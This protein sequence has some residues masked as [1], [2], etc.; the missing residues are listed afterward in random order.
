MNQVSD[1]IV[2]LRDIAGDAAANAATRVKPS[3]SELSQIDR[4][5]DDNTWHD[6]PVISKESIK[7]QFKSQSRT[8]KPLSGQDVQEVAVDAAQAADTAGP[9]S[10][11]QQDG[12]TSGVDARAGAQAGVQ[13][14][15][16]RANENI[17]DDTK[18]R[19]KN[20]HGRVMD[21]LGS[22]IPQERRDRTIWRLKKMVVEVQGHKCV[23]IFQESSFM[24]TDQF[25]GITNK[26]SRLCSV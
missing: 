26:P 10:R 22:K 7:N 21:Y 25:L 16:Q 13:G 3:E 23:L 17:P 4:P 20:Y 2:L 8:Q 11:D 6:V 18:D 15:R 19:A 9:G 24:I 5:A 14:L 12:T 1:A